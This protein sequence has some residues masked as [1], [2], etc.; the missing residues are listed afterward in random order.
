[1][2]VQ[3][4][5]RRRTADPAIDSA[6]GETE[7]ARPRLFPRRTP[8]ETEA[9]TAPPRRLGR[10]KDPDAKPRTVPAKKKTPRRWRNRRNPISTAIWMAAV[11]AAAVLGLGML[12]TYSDANQANDVVH[13]IMR[14][15]DWLATPFRDMFVNADPKHQLY[16]NWA[17]AAGAYLVLGRALAWLTRW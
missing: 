4:W 9:G 6:E 1:M 14:T 13:A 17:V 11:A 15:G 5:R 12:L 7:T 2:A 8:P 16:Q 10:L 3:I